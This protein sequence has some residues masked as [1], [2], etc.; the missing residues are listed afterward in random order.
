MITLYG[1]SG[2]N[3]AKARAS[4]LFKG[5]AFDEVDVDLIRKSQEF[6]RL[7][8]IGRVPLIYDDGMIVHDSLFIAEYLDRRCPKTFP[9]L[10]EA[11]DDRTRAYT[12]VARLERLFNIAA[13]L[14]A[15]RLGFF[16]LVDPPTAA[17]SG[18][19][20]IN[21][22]MA[23]ELEL[24]LRQNL[25]SL[26][27]LLDDGDHVDRPAA[28]YAEFAVFA[29]LTL[30]AQIGVCTDPLSDWMLRRTTSFPFD[31]MF[32]ADQDSVRTKI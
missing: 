10:P 19:Y 12:I 26:A 5:L 15:K 30:L 32:A 14:V 31:K 23:G 24:R 22:A 25:C 21:D 8:P 11:L 27:T 28:P 13:P 29:F 3:V 2:P 17:C 4:L 9:L 1:V 7:T 6:L 18:Y 20:L 16:D